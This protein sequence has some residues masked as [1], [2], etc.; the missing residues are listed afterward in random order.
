MTAAGKSLSSSRKLG[1][2]GLRKNRAGIGEP[3]EQLD[4]EVRN[5]SP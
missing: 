5:V 3:A 2:I 4:R 1:E